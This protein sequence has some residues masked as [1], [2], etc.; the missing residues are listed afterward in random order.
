VLTITVPFLERMFGFG[1][2]EHWELA[3]VLLTGIISILISES[4]K[5]P[6]VQRFM[7]RK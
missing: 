4:L 7:N 3:L 6:V 5:I 1:A 2:I